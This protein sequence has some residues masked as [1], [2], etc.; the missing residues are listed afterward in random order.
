MRHGE[1]G[2]TASRH[3]VGNSDL[4]LSPVGRLQ[5]AAMREVVLG[6][7]P[8]TCLCSPMRRCLETVEAIIDGTGIEPEV[9]AGLR[10]INFGCWEKRTF[11]EVSEMDPEGVRRWLRFDRQF[12]FGTGEKLGTCFSRVKREAAWIAS[13]PGETILVCAHGGVIR[14]MICHFLGLP[15][16]HCFILDV[17][18]A[19][20]AAIDLY[21]TGKG[22]LAFLMPCV[23]QPDKR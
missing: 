17:G 11:A 13:T 12:S 3:F 21:E 20:L 14:G 6:H 9:R 2:L 5:A 15:L 18:P 23:Y 16:R 10:E 1:T 8:Q 4:E 7:A 19:S 22:V